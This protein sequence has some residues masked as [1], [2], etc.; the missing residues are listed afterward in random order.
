MP[1][2]YETLAERE[3]TYGPFKGQARITQDLKR[4]IRA[5][6]GWEAL[7]DDQRE[8]LDMIVSKIARILNGDPDCIDS[9]HD[10]A[11]YSTLI[12]RRLSSP[13]S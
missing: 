6:S 1:L 12:E 7:R 9:W 5:W 3:K 4:D 8:A 2:I 13:K 11:G 10:I